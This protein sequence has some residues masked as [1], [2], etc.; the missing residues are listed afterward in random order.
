M[1]SPPAVAGDPRLATELTCAARRDPGS[2]APHPPAHRPAG[3]FLP[4]GPLLR[5]LPLS[6]TALLSPY[7]SPAQPPPLPRLRALAPGCW[8]RRQWDAWW[9]RRWLKEPLHPRESDGHGGSRE[10][11]VAAAGDRCRAKTC[12]HLLQE[13]DEGAGAVGLRLVALVGRQHARQ[14]HWS[15]LSELLYSDLNPFHLHHRRRYPRLHPHASCGMWLRHAW[16]P[17]PD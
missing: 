4:R 8:G 12:I 17:W 3:S 1:E 9:G 6:T 2:G 14:T 5:R 15:R 13:T 10:N 11:D 7:S 16:D